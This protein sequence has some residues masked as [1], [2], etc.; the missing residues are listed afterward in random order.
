MF[1]IF[2]VSSDAWMVEYL[3]FIFHF[4]F[5]SFSIP[6]FAFIHRQ[7]KHLVHEMSL[8]YSKSTEQENQWMYRVAV[9]GMVWGGG[10]RWGWGGTQRLQTMGLQQ[11]GLDRGRDR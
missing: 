11:G 4:I 5:Q 3:G 10:C 2:E 7:V 9:T 6:V 8:L 1:Y